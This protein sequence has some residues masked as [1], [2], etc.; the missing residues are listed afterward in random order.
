MTMWD[1]LRTENMS[2]AYGV[3]EY[4]VRRMIAKGIIRPDDCIRIAGQKEWIRVS[5]LPANVWKDAPPTEEE[6][7]KAQAEREQKKASASHSQLLPVPEPPKPKEPDYPDAF[8]ETVALEISL[9]PLDIENATVGEQGFEINQIL[10]DPEE[11][12]RKPRLT[13][14]PLRRSVRKE[15]EEE[16]AFS[17]RPKRVQEELDLTSLVDITFLL[18]P[19]F[20]VTA[21]FALQKSLEIPKPNPDDSSPQAQS[22]DDLRSKNI[23][24]EV[25]GDNSVLLDDRPVP[26]AE[27]VE[28]IRREVHQSGLNEV[29]IKASG[30]AFHETVVAV[31]DAANAV[32]VERIRLATTDGPGET[33]PY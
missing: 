29:V 23:I 31:F 15:E 2:H 28:L 18:I 21:T 19:F 30:N 16:A 24:L 13:P 14:P 6:R 12:H 32:G 22:I 4:R 20:M 27:L 3:E 8:A 5:E 25:R 26:T 17:F 10:D 11:E 9:P 1:V 7:R 33:S